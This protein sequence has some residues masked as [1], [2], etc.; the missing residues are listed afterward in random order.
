MRNG[1]HEIMQ[2]DA[3]GR[4]I[5]KVPIFIVGILT[6]YAIVNAAA[7]PPSQ[8]VPEQPTPPEQQ[9]QPPQLSPQPE[10]LLTTARGRLVA[11]LLDQ[12]QQQAR[13]AEASLQRHNGAN[14]EQTPVL[15]ADVQA[16]QERIQNT[17]Q[18]LDGLTTVG[19]AQELRQIDERIQ[20]LVRQR[21]EL[22]R[23]AKQLE[24]QLQQLPPSQEAGRR[25]LQGEIGRIQG[26]LRS[27]D[28]QLAELRRQRVQ[29]DYAAAL[30]ARQQART[31]QEQAKEKTS[32]ASE[33]ARQVADLSAQLKQL[34][35]LAQ[36][37]QREL[38]QIQDK[39]GPRARE[40]EASLEG[41]RRQTQ[42][43]EERLRSMEREQA[44]E[45][46]QAA[47]RQRQILESSIQQLGRRQE[48]LKQSVDAI[49]QELRGVQDQTRET[50]Q[51]VRAAGE[52]SARRGAA[53]QSIE[54]FKAES[55][56]Q[57]EELRNQVRSMD[58]RLK[59][60]TER[61]G[62]G[63][64]AFRKELDSLRTDMQRMGLTLGRLER[65]RLDAQ[66]GLKNQVQQLDRQVSEL[67]KDVL[68][69]QG[70]LNMLLSQMG[71][72]TVGSAGCPWGW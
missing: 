42:A 30:Q 66:A 72:S 5:G 18:E 33:T 9:V 25:W 3:I 7:V 38:E 44:M 61:A 39:E 22:A 24:A 43:I 8:T 23:T 13:E 15:R 67:R 52:E 50:Q 55:M 51:Q 48:E 49:R 10:L 70:S 14:D 17:Q 35:E 32:Q 34:Q 20:Q 68:L 19:P 47:D 60:A 54:Q 40:L 69:V 16:L 27:L 46:L 1:L 56:H 41:V 65:E 29:A 2:R 36:R 21:E 31:E 26:Q 4:Q 6:I 53:Q 62:T 37:N 28:E 12:L 57:Q 58:E 64:E 45:K 63:T 59:V 11:Q 71:R